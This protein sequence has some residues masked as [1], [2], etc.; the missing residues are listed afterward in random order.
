MTLR[1][2]LMLSHLTAEKEEEAHLRADMES[3][4]A[5]AAALDDGQGKAEKPLAAPLRPDVPRPSFPRDEMLLNAPR[6]K[7]AMCV[8]PRTVE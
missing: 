3:I 7:D 4:S 1:E 5:F 2:A 6:V 8:A